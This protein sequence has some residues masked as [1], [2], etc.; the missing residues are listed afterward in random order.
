MFFKIIKVICFPNLFYNL[1]YYYYY[2]VHFYIYY[3]FLPVDTFSVVFVIWMPLRC[4][5]TTKKIE[6]YAAVDTSLFDDV[7]AMTPL[8]SLIT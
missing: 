2:F 3:F 4:L 1:K 5:F 7:T 6:F 8:H